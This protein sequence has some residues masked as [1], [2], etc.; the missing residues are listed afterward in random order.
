MHACMTGIYQNF[1]RNICEQILQIP[2]ESCISCSEQYETST[3]ELMSLTS[4]P[5]PLVYINFNFCANLICTRHQ[6]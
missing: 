1:E 6:H 5:N 2:T 4:L 3:Q